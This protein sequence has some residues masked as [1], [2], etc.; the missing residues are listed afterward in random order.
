[1]PKSASAFA[2]GRA[3]TTPAAAVSLGLQFLFLTTTGLYLSSLDNF[4]SIAMLI[5]AGGRSA[6]LLRDALSETRWKEIGWVSKLYLYQ[7]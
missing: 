2:D 4:A 5:G 7:D 1:L 3:F 6:R